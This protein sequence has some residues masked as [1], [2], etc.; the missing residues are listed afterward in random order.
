MSMVRSALAVLAGVAALTITSFA[1]EMAATP[2]LTRWF[3]ADFSRST[4]MPMS[5]A[6]W[7][8]TTLYTLVC[9]AAGGYVTAWRAPSK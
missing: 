3:P 7:L 8:I 2:L 6:P 1:L 4:G 9:I 5:G